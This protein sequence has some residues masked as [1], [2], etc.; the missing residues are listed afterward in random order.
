MLQGWAWRVVGAGGQR[1]QV[2]EEII[3][4]LRRH[5]GIGRVGEGRIEMLAVLSDPSGHV[6]AELG[7]R[8]ASETVL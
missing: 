4:I 3:D 6:I 1:L 2:A 5:A 8:P 7:H